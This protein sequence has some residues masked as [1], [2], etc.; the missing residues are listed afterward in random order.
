MKPIQWQ[1][2]AQIS[3]LGGI[4]AGVWFYQANKAR[5]QQASQE[6]VDHVDL[7]RLMGTWYEIARFPNF[8]QKEEWVGATDN[9]YPQENGG[10]EVIY[11][12]HE[13]QFD[14][15]LKEMK[16][17]MWRDAKDAPTGKLKFQALWPFSADYWVIDL[18]TEYEYLVIGYPNHSMLWIM[19]RTPSLDES[20]YREI[21]ERVAHQGYEV[22]KLIKVPQPSDAKAILAP[23]AQ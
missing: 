9:Y 16:A 23:S 11:R 21:L 13:K 20:T 6:V 10:I 18:G 5:A 14:A 8:F 3:L 12:Y 4:L 22:S 19:S 15:P 7:K 2:I 17:K 1:R